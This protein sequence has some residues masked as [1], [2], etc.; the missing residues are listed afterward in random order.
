MSIFFNP[1][2]PF[3]GGA[4]PHAPQE[5]NPSAEAVQVDGPPPGLKPWLALVV[6]AWAPADLPPQLARPVPQA[7][8][9]AAQTP[10]SNVAAQA[11][12][13]GAWQPD[14]AALQS[15]RPLPAQITAVRVDTP[16]I[17]VLEPLLTAIAGWTLGDPPPQG[18]ARFVVQAVPVNNPPFAGGMSTAE[19]AAVIASWQ[20]ADPPP[21]LP[22]YLAQAGAAVAAANPPFS[23]QVQLV[24]VLPGWQPP[25]L[26]P[27][28]VA[29]LPASVTAVA[30][31]DPP[32]SGRTPLPGILATWQAPDPAP[33]V[34]GKLSAGVPGQS[35]DAPPP[36]RRQ[37]F[38]VAAAWQ[39]DPP[40][41]VQYRLTVPSTPTVVNNPPFGLRQPLY[42]IVASWQPPDAQ[43]PV[44]KNLS[45]QL[46]AVRVDNPPPR[47]RAPQLGIIQASWFEAQ[48][49]LPRS[50]Y[51][52]ITLNVVGVRFAN[53]TLS[54]PTAVNETLAQPGPK[55]EIL[56]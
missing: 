4:Q 39:V 55:A 31:N 56:E 28:T 34:E 44:A 5:L 15:Q 10:A 49:P 48:P 20:A 51:A 50:R 45:P 46:V 32:Y 26:Q 1:P 12:I 35:V 33:Q 16:P 21:W 42:P 9:A 14:Q 30:V 22:R 27:Q 11:A 8:A 2:P 19:T 23:Q 13:V 18:P 7:P 52:V 3:V 40:P 41:F 47:G 43:A 38:P 53:E 37:P 24:A 29:R 17:P 54:G 36:S 6:A 25:P